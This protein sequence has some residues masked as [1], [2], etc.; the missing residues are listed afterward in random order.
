M[1]AVILDAQD[2]EILGLALDLLSSH[3]DAE[4]ANARKRNNHAKQLAMQNMRQRIANVRIRLQAVS[5]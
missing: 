1:S 3:T 2:R 4:L 5:P